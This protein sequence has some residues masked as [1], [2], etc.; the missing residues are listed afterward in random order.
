[1]NAAGH[2]ALRRAEISDLVAVG[3]DHL[4]FG[5]CQRA[6]DRFTIED[7]N[8]VG[9]TVL[10]EKHVALVPLIAIPAR[11]AD[12]GDGQV[13]CQISRAIQMNRCIWPAPYASKRMI[14]LA[15]TRVRDV[16]RCPAIAPV[17]RPPDTAGPDRDPHKRAVEHH[18][19]L[20][21][22]GALV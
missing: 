7:V 19:G 14:G 11:S 16:T 5:R 1:M 21:G 13:A 10:P 20:A 12:P 15:V 17:E 8:L 22:G 18:D 6:H 4:V 9:F 3:I 2:G